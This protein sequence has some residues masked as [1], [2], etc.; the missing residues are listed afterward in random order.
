MKLFHI[1]MTNIMGV[2]KLTKILIFSLLL[3]SCK[4]E[5]SPTEYKKWMESSD[6]GMYKT[7]E[8]NNWVFTAQYETSEYLLLLNKGPELIKDC[9]IQKELDHYGETHS[10]LL[11]ITDKKGNSPLKFNVRNELEYNAR[12]QYLN[13]EVTK[14]CFLLSGNDTLKCQFAH[15]ERD[16]GIS[17]NLKINFAFDKAESDETIQFCFRDK[18]FNNGMI[19]FTFFKEDFLNLPELRNK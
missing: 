11:N 19:K 8:I 10:V 18:L 5:F 7:K 2:E 13:S 17:P 4:K 16:F 1:Q 12:I 6:N 14:D 15:L 9:D 3:I